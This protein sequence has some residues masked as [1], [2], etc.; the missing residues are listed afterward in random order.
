[1]DTP[2]R[3]ISP[4]ETSSATPLLALNAVCIDTET[5]GL[6]TSRAKVLQIGGVRISKGGIV[7]DDAFERLIDPGE[8]IPA[9]SSDI[10]GIFDRDVAGAA[11]FRAVWPQFRDW[12]GG[13]IVLG[14]SIGF[15]LAVLKRE[16]DLAQMPW[17]A[18]R[19]LDVR[20]LAQLAAPQ[21]PDYSLDTIA[22][23]LNIEIRN[24]HSAVG[25]AVATAEI[26]VALLP[27]LQERGIRTV[28]EAER[29]VQSLSSQVLGE[30]E[31]GWHDMVRK[32]QPDQSIA[33]LARIDSFPY[34]HKVGDVMHAPP[35]FVEAG[36][37]LTDVLNTLMQKQI[38]S[39][40][41][42]GREETGII[43]ERDILRAIDDGG[44][45]AL[46]QKVETVAK[47]PLQCVGEDAYVYRAIA[48]MSSR[49]FR[50]LG[51]C[52][53][54]GGIVGALSARDLL[55]Q[56][57]DDAISLGD[58]IDTSMSA[59]DLS[60]AWANLALVAQGLVGEDVDVR[61]VAA[62]ISKELCELT[63]RAAEI[64]EIELREAGMG[65]PPSRYAVMVLGSAGRGESLLAMD[66]DNAIIY[67]GGAKGGTDDKW[68][69]ELGKRIADTLN[70]AGVPY[71]K[72][73]VMASNRA[74]RM[75]AADWKD[76]VASW[77]SRHKPEDILNTDIFFD[78][79]A[80]TGATEL[81]DEVLEHAFDI[82]SKAREFLHLMSVN[83][84]D[85]P[86]S[87]GWFGR[88]RLSDGRIDLKK[89][90]IMPIFSAARVVA[91]RHGV[92]ARSTPERLAGVKGKC[93]CPD[94]IIDNLIEAHKVLL[95]AILEQQLKDLD[96]GIPLSNSVAVA[97]LA[98]VKRDRL[99]WALG[100]VR[101][102]SNLLG[103]PVSII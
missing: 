12:A 41:V 31:A 93:D 103:D 60:L 11:G 43:T 50:H 24:R 89:S 73:G 64:G 36:V 9:G 95:G 3:P 66:Q 67:A 85:V 35:V 34:R 55:K 17:L 63:R 48:A 72:G 86:E 53:S 80:V 22:S 87:I 29:G 74:W 83:A 5:T 37:R 51:V 68:F 1:M 91:I 26:F 92:R 45:G 59:N 2:V 7:A 25:D 84:A 71:C 98:P 39:V 4:A 47:F 77:I 82:G 79:V 20:H 18:P 78:A 8:P 42:S 33:A 27:Q 75:S 76:N 14:Y 6:D 40:F 21:L 16:H 49:G 38:S 100:Q 69:A 97:E 62:I 57:G 15:D 46:E 44:A 94:S 81:A 13:A 88:I 28:A 101:S 90:G 54:D 32:A 52:G 30:A 70:V 65:E 10:H 61:D 23:W 102:V 58:R 99:K 96:A 19:S 56:R